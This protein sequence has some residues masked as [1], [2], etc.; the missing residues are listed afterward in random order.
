MTYTFRPM[1]EA[2]ANEI[3]AWRYEP[4]YDFYD[5]PFDVEQEREMLDPDYRNAHYWAARDVSGELVGFYEYTLEGDD[6]KIGL[7]L[8]PDHTGRGLGEAFVRAGMDFG[9]TLYEPERF[10]LAVVK[11]NER[12]RKIYERLGF[13]VD[14]EAAWDIDGKRWEFHTMSR[15]A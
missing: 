2:E 9:L 14:G 6:L 5:V 13:V 11:F 8:R 12:A 7:G 15:P 3:V 10:T 1:T 4:P